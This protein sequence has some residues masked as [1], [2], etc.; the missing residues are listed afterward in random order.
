M[1]KG[2]GKVLNPG[3]VF[4]LFSP[5]VLLLRTRRRHLLTLAR[6][7]ALRATSRRLFWNQAKMTSKQEPWTRLSH[8]KKLPGWV[9]YNPRT[10]RPPPL[11]GDTKQMKILSWN[12]N[13]LRN[14]V[15][16]GGFSSALAQRENFDVLC[17]Q[18]THLKEGDV[19]DFM[20]LLPGYE[21]NYWSCSVARLDYSGTGVISRVKPISV[22]YGIG[23][24]EHDQEGRVITLEFEN[25]YLVNAYVPNSGRGL[26][27][28]VYR[29]DSWDPSFTDFVEK[30]ESFKPVIVCGDLNCARQSIDIHNPPAKT[31]DA[32]F[33]EEER[34]SFQINF[35][36]RGFVDTFR[37][38]HPKAVGYTFWG[39]NQ[40]RNNKGWRLDYFLASGSIIDRV[41]DSYILPDVTSS[42]HSPI[43]L[44][45]KL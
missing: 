23:I 27:R 8:S 34:E 19:K 10:M 31:E 7:A 26:R 4:S 1:P 28:L 41:H 44:V 2:G 24:A 5:P 45:L 14:I 12:V 9:A 15:Q 43:G 39:E 37:K 11:S 13:G 25:F 38:Q 22:Q 3:I 20:N 36:M 32:G 6:T 18:E 17:L 40:R 35:D 42:D 16:S 30:L 21:Y 33:T 29:V